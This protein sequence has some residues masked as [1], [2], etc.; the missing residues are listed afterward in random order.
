M[1]SLPDDAPEDARPF[2]NPSGRP[3]PALIR[4]IPW[5]S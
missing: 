2:T 5:K 1:E 4:A 3:L